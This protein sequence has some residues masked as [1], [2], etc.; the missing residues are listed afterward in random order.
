M[1][2]RYRKVTGHERTRKPAKDKEKARFESLRAE[3][4]MRKV[5]K[6]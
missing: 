5:S 6:L 2:R 3:F 1:E 4:G